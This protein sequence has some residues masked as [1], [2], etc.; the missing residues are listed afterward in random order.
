MPSD[1]LNSTQS[2]VYSDMFVD[3][4]YVYHAL[5]EFVLYSKVHVFGVL[6]FTIEIEFPSSS[7]VNLK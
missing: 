2:F 7:E 4:V 5:F 6:T 1:F 3:I